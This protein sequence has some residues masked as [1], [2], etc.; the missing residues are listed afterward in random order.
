M[1]GGPT[2]VWPGPGNGG[3]TLKYPVSPTNFPPPT[4]GGPST[5]DGGT[6]INTIASGSH[7]R[8]SG[9]TKTS[10]HKTKLHK[11]KAVHPKKHQLLHTP[12]HIPTDIEWQEF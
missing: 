11:P 7:S 4:F 6:T 2:Q 10:S 3:G 9:H 1:S 12:H 5:Q 8:H